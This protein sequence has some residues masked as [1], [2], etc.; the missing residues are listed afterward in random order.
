MTSRYTSIEKDR[1]KDIKYMVDCL[2]CSNEGLSW[3]KEGVRGRHVHIRDREKD[4]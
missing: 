3:R 1:E 4:L 2:Q